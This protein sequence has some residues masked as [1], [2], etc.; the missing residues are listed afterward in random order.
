MSSRRLL[1][2]A[3]R[4]RKRPA[5]S[6]SSAQP[7]AHGGAELPEYEPPDCPLDE[8]SRRAIAALANPADARDYPRRLGESYEFLKDSVRDLNDHHVLR[9]GQLK[10]MQEKRRERGGAGAEPSEHERQ[11]AEAVEA[12]RDAV[13]G[14][15]RASEAAVR[16]V[17]DWQAELADEEKALDEAVARLE[18]DYAQYAAAAQEQDPDDEPPRPAGARALFAEARDGLRAEYAATTMYQRYGL[19][20][21]YIQFK[22]LWHDAVHADDGRPLPEAARWFGRDGAPAEDADAEDDDDDLIIAGE[23]QDFRC[24]LSMQV[25]TNPYTAPACKHTFEKAAIYE[26][27][28]PQPNRVVQCPQTGCAKVRRRRLL[29]LPR[30]LYDPKRMLTSGVD[31]L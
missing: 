22:K 24:P 18:E 14:L 28:G 2:G 5:A 25:M 12:L 7:A 15:T 29:P 9:R 19:S 30:R 10:G 23:I 26:Y 16:A 21:E 20:N 3:E 27:L 4:N 13:P 17:I 11:L 6:S 8:T 1:T 31:I